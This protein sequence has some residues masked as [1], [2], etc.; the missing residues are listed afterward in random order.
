MLGPEDVL[1]RR[2][3]APQI[4]GRVGPPLLGGRRQPAPDQREGHVRMVLSVDLGVDGQ[5]VVVALARPRRV[6]AGPREVAGDH[7]DAGAIGVL[8]RQAGRVASSP[9]RAT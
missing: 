9:A 4:A 5:G 2:E 7:V 1:P 3:R 8:G 6:E